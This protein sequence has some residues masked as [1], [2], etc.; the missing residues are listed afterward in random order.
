M[1]FSDDSKDNAHLVTLKYRH[2]KKKNM[3]NNIFRNIKIENDNANRCTYDSIY[4][5]NRQNTTV[6]SSNNYRHKVID[7]VSIR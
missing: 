4:N 5:N 6:Q 2:F 7:T 3:Y 1:T